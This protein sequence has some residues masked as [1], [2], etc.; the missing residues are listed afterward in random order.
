MTTASKDRR[1]PLT[2]TK[3]GL[4]IS[5]KRD[6]TRT[7]AIEYQVRHPKYGKY[8]ARRS[9]IHVHDEKNASRVGDRVEIAN[10]RPMSKTKSWRLVRIVEQAPGAEQ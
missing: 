8:L 7:V 6:K 3:T 9:K 1:K 2:G 4:V 5:D 10:C